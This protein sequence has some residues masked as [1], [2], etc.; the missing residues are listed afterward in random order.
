MANEFERRCVGRSAE[1]IPRFGARLLRRYEAT[2]AGVGF[3]DSRQPLRRASPGWS[4]DLV[5]GSPS[6][7][8][9]FGAKYEIRAHQACR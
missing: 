8:A 9:A 1:L 3:E 7:C 4:N 6:V 5:V 2:A